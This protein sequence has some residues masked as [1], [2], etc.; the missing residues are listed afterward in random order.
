MFVRLL[1]LGLL[2][3]QCA[4]PIKATKKQLTN[5]PASYMR[6]IPGAGGGKGIMF[7]VILKDSPE[8][9]TI[10]RFVINHVEVPADIE[11][12]LIIASVFYADTEPTMD[13]PDPEPVDP[14]LFNQDTFEAVIYFSTNGIE[15]S[16]RIT[17]FSEEEQPL[18]Q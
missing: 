11:D 12:S 7:K 14:V 10:N 13:N 6:Y 1:L 8:T 3:A 9:F 18:Y 15:D 17:N 2:F 16:V 5:A 4:S